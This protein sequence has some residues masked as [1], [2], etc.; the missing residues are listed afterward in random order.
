M[1]K[2]INKGF[3]LIELLVVIAIIGILA[4]MLLP[5]LAKAKKKANRLKCSNK[6]GQQGKAHIGFAGDAGTFLWNLLDR[7]CLDAY[8]ADYRDLPD[9]KAHHH[10]LQH[11]A[12]WGDSTIVG[13][14]TAGF[15]Y[16]RGHH[17]ADVRFVYTAP[18]IRRALDSSKMLLSPSDAKMKA[19]NQTDSTGGNLDGGKWASIPCGA[20]GTGLFYGHFISNRAISYAIHTGADDQVPEG[21]LGFTRNCVGGEWTWDVRADGYYLPNDPSFSGTLTAGAVANNWIGADGKES[22][23]TVPSWHNSN[24]GN[25]KMSGLDASQGNYTKADGSAK[26]GDDAQWQEAIG[27]HNA[28]KSSRS[29]V[30]GAAGASKCFNRPIY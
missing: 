26:Q 20:P 27:T 5:T 15:A 12:H 30:N 6:L 23:G 4:S 22:G 17:L 14:V 29:T 21:I 28:N 24:G 19:G 11:G 3:T 7:D 8:A 2:Q 10:T 1:K 16:H 18:G 13:N 9:M 25:T